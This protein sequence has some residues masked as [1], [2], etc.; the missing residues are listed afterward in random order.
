[1]LCRRNTPIAEV[2][3][4]PKP[5]VKERPIGT[6]PDLEVPDSFFEPLPDELLRAFEGGEEAS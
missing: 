6:D 1:M 5:L 2:R 4:L 3:P